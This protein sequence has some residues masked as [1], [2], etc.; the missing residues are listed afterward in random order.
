[1]RAHVYPCHATEEMPVPVSRQSVEGRRTGQAK[2][3]PA[4]QRRS[5][6]RAAGRALAELLPLAAETE[7]EA[8]P[9]E[10]PLLM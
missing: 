1:M 6:H 5:E 10:I 4:R 7:V 3:K 8:S 9:E 2:F